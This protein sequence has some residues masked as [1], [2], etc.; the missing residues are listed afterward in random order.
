[1]MQLL[2]R[3]LALILSMLLIIMPMA[4]LQ[5]AI[6]GNETIIN[7][8]PS[9]L[10]RDN[11]QALLGQ[12]SARQQMQVW[13]VSPELITAR[14]KRLTDAELARINQ[15]ADTLKAGGTNVLGVL[16]IIF[17]VFV[18]TDVI[19]ATNIFPFIHPVK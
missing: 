8:A 18:I 19:G 10:T 13:G 9:A 4:P 16:L 5:A 7:Q 6:I 14:I 12:E 1:M 2:Q 17:I 3:P 15:E 11:M